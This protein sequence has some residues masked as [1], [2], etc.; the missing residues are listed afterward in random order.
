MMKTSRFCVGD[1]FYLL[2]NKILCGS[3]YEERMLFASLQVITSIIIII[4]IFM[5]IFFITRL[6]L[7][8]HDLCF[9]GSARPSRAVE[10]SANPIAL[11]ADLPIQQQLKPR[12]PKLLPA[13]PQ[14]RLHRPPKQPVGGSQVRRRHQSFA[15][16][17]FGEE[18]HGSCHVA[19]HLQ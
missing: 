9:P 14:Q 4:I 3:D 10:E 2:D 16:N 7:H 6:H 17:C 15:P 8:L 13:S 12:S 18:A 5:I 1:Q 19:D 11:S